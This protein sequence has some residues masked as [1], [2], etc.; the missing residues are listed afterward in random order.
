ML[1]QCAALYNSSLYCDWLLTLLLLLFACVQ[2]AEYSINAK[3]TG[4]LRNTAFLDKW[5][6]HP[7]VLY[8]RALVEVSLKTV[9]A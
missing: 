6:D 3:S 2:M 7:D 8:A 9:S 1:H 4:I 5:V